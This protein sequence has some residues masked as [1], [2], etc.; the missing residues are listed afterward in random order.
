MLYKNGIKE[1]RKYTRCD[2]RVGEVEPS[3]WIAISSSVVLLVRRNALVLP[4]KERKKRERKRKKEMME[5]REKGETG[6]S[7]GREF[8]SYGIILRS[9]LVTTH[10]LDISREYTAKNLFNFLV[11]HFHSAWLRGKPVNFRP[12]WPNI[13]KKCVQDFAIISLPPILVF[14]YRSIACSFIHSPIQLL[15]LSFFEQLPISFLIRCF[16]STFVFDFTM[17]ITFW[18][19]TREILQIIRLKL[20]S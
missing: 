9:K 1:K 14:L 5:R 10:L 20:N 19:G 18:K 6:E 17:D 4:E 13:V 11:R 2:N 16:R 12:S 8:V 7:S 3:S 15:S